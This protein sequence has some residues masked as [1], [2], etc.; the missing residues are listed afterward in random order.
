MKEMARSTKSWWTANAMA[1]QQQGVILLDTA[2][3]VDVKGAMTGFL[4]DI[5]NDFCGL[6]AVVNQ[7]MV[8]SQ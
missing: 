8:D 6:G 5:K 4:A 7:V 3:N 1:A 2:F